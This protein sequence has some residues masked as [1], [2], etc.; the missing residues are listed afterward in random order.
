[1]TLPEVAQAWLAFAVFGVASEN[2]AMHSECQSA[3]HAELWGQRKTASCSKV[4]EIAWRRKGG[5]AY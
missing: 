3:L 4:V 1:M 2:L 5:M